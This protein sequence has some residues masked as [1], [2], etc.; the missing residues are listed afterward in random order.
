MKSPRELETATDVYAVE[1]SIGEGGSGSVYAVK[2]G[3]GNVWAAKVLSPRTADSG[4]RRRFKNELEFLLKNQHRNIVTVRDHGIAEVEGSR[5]PF[6]VMPLFSSTLRSVLKKGITPQSVLPLF[7][8]VLD[9]VE[10]AHLKGVIHRDLKPENILVDSGG[11]HVVVADF[12]IAHFEE[13]DLYTAVET[14]AADRLANFQYAAPEQ[15]QRGAAVGQ[16]ADIY[17]LGLIL[18]E[19][20]T[21]RV[22]QG[23]GYARIGELV[24]D[25][26]YLDDVVES[27]I[28]QDPARRLATVELIKKEIGFRGNVALAQQALDAARNRVVPK[29]EPG[30]VEP[31]TIQ[32][33]EWDKGQLKMLLNRTPEAGW[34]QSFREPGTGSRTYRLDIHWSQVMFQ[35]NTATIAVESNAAQAAID[36]IKGWMAIATSEYRDSLVQA[37]RRREQQD[38]ERIARELREAEERARVNATLRV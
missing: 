20:Y 2:D 33:V 31:V 32:S 18:N 9:G 21:Q 15:R 26:A 34:I 3:A 14:R 7:S 22:I 5:V 29:Y 27:M 4:K 30:A 13:E 12:G 37:A 8:Q 16:T 11:S 1:G 28:Q 23:A 6:F 10:A 24:G 17:A 19:M 38:R 36:F 35:G 25:F